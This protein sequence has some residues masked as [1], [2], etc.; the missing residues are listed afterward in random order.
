M[1]FGRALVPVAES[2]AFDKLRTAAMRVDW[3]PDLG[4]RIGSL[5]WWRG[6]ATCAALCATAYA[7]APPLDNPILAAIWWACR[8][9]FCFTRCWST[10]W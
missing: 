9:S 3:V 4:S 1:S 5:D 7:F 8:L 6:A 10:R 2:T